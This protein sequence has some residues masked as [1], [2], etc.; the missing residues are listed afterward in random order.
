MDFIDGEAIG[1][2]ES[3]DDD[4]L[5][6]SSQTDDIIRPRKRR[7]IAVDS[8]DESGNS[9]DDDVKL[10]SNDYSQDDIE[11]DEAEHRS[12]YED[13]MH[14]PQF[15]TTQKDTYVTQLTQ[16]WSSPTHIRGPRW[17]RK[18]STPEPAANRPPPAAVERRPS[19]PTP[20]AGRLAA[21]TADRNSSVPSPPPRATLDDDLTAPAGLDEDDFEADDPDLLDALISAERSQQHHGLSNGN[22]SNRGQSGQ[23]L[24]Q[25]TLFGMPGA[26]HESTG[27]QATRAHNWPLANR[28]EKPTHHKID[29]EAMKT[30]VYPTNLGTIRDYQYNIV[31]KGLY[32]NLLVALPTGLGK[33]FIAATIMLNWYRWTQQTQIVF[34]APTKPLVAQ[35]I[36][37]CFNIAGIPRSQTTLLTGEIQPAIRA[38]EWQEKRVFFMTPQ[39]LINDLKT[40]IADPKK[41]VLLV[42]DEAH[43]ATGG[44]AY[45]EVVKFLQ[46]FNTSFRVLALTATPGSTVESVQQVIN[47]L[48]I[49]R[50]EIRTE[51]SIDIRQYVHSRDE[52]LEVFE[53][54]L[55]ILEMLDLFRLACQPLQNV[56]LR[57]RAT[58]CKDPTENTL[59]G[60][61]KSYD[62]WKKSE[63]GKAAPDSVKW[64]LMKVFQMKIFDDESYG[65]GK[66]A[67]QVVEHQAFK[68][69][70]TRLR[71]WVNNPDFVGH[72]KLEY[73]KSVA[74]NHFM[75]AGEGRGAAGGRPPSETRIMVFSHYRDSAEEIVRTLK[76]HEPMVRPHIFVGQ[77]STKG[78]E[79]MDQKKQQDVIKQF[80]AGTYNVLVATSIGEEGLDIGEVDLIVCYDAS[81]SPIRMLQRMGRT[82][83][84]RAGNVQV[85]LMKGKE[86]EAF[87]RAKDNYRK[88][89]EL[90]ESGKEFEFHEDKSPRIVPK[91][92]QPVVDKRVV[93][94][95]LENTQDTSIEPKKR[96]A[97]NAKKP[98]KKF[99]MPDD[100][101]TG[102]KFLGA[103]KS[104]KKQQIVKPKLD[105]TVAP[106][107]PL[108]QVLLTADEEAERQEKHGEVSGTQTQYTQIPRLDAYPASYVKLG[109][110][111]RVKH[112][113]VA[114]S[115]ATTLQ[116]MRCRTQGD[117]TPP[118]EQEVEAAVR[119]IPTLAQGPAAAKRS[120]THRRSPKA[121]AKNPPKVPSSRTVSPPTLEHDYGELGSFI[122]DA[123]PDIMLGTFDLS[124]KAP[125]A[126]ASEPFWISQPERDQT[127]DV[128]DDMPDLE[129]IFGLPASPKVAKRSTAKTK[130]P[131]RGKRRVIDSDDDDE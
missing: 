73:L 82:G 97:K 38:E 89:Q 98:P 106:L 103:G 4:V 61:K 83:R 63:A 20:A 6:P 3:G 70:M 44:Y 118:T 36:D 75:D 95:P 91:E 81:K 52:N 114:Q 12:K 34:V 130:T 55:E 129:D 58:W 122:D 46:R 15:V 96:K 53:Y 5:V 110:I 32:H 108:D 79:G 39:T 94:I 131:A 40:G 31:H 109:R 13:F 112:S 33:T 51:D 18:A 7:R 65:G 23:N 92:I 19:G 87:A 48:N 35:Q 100:V 90:I 43:K 45:V 105:D 27:A 128:D 113:R 49:S 102:F 86:E 28:A 120:I 41:I 77:S 78:S 67:K 107:P 25:T 99:H 80:K 111:G 104:S 1:G 29:T 56:M 64:P 22:A 84:K 127:K 88:M 16:P 124:S 17:R 57:H 14:V 21:S 68:D 123:P 8:S 24:R 72:P 2:G 9:S 101:E 47:G 71:Q 60:L 121:H 66:Y 26:N 117:C 119:N 11:T 10:P 74:L 62:E 69:M 30:W 37:A 85:L 42:V 125:A 76:K 54:S 116:N 126:S 59:F 50:I 93:E 115:L